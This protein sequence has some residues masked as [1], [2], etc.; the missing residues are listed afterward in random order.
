MESIAIVIRK[1][2]D[3]QYISF[4]KILRDNIEKIR[5]RMMLRTKYEL[6]DKLT[7]HLVVK[8]FKDEKL[9]SELLQISKI[10]MDKLGWYEQSTNLREDAGA[11]QQE[12][13][14]GKISCSLCARE[15][16]KGGDNETNTQST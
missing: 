3:L 8:G 6:K 7:V 15:C 9:K 11:I 2:H 10:N 14:T 4:E 12:H 13:R 5:Y 16:T 1:H